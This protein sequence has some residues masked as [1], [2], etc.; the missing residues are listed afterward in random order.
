MAAD[1][2]MVLA[3]DWSMP[4]EVTLVNSVSL[5]VFIGG[6]GAGLEQTIDV[7]QL[8]VARGRVARSTLQWINGGPIIG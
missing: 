6:L 1:R 3:W 8:M 4:L 2:G 5:T 7:W